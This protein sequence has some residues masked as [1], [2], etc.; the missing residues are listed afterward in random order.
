MQRPYPVL[1]HV[2]RSNFSAQ[3]A[4]KERAMTARIERLVADVRAV[5]IQRVRFSSTK[6][7]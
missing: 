7:S 4:T 6:V 5:G 3:V 2:H 1:W